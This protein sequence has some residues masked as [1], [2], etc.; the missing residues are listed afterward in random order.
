MAFNFESTKVVT[1]SSGGEVNF[2]GDRALTIVDTG[3]LTSLTMRMPY[4]IE[5]G[6]SYFITFLGAV[7]SLTWDVGE[8]K[9]KVGL[10]SAVIAGERLNVAYVGS[11]DTWY[12]VV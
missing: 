2:D 10:P 11:T 7:L 4:G 3:L 6:Q 5:N 8:G 9:S 12:R 1:P